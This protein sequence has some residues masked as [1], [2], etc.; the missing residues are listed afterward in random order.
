MDLPTIVILI[1]LFLNLTAFVAFAIDKWNAVRGKG[2][3]SERNLLVLSAGGPF[4]AYTAM[5]AVHHKTRKRKFLLVPVFMSVHLV[6][7]A[8]LIYLVFRPVLGFI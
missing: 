2:R 8:Y 3:V 1:Y 7:L 4:G 5:K 6:V